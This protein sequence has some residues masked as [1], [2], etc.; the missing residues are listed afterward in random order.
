VPDVARHLTQPRRA[1]LQILAERGP[2]EEAGLTEAWR[3]NRPDMSARHARS[4]PK[5]IRHLL[6]RL[7]ILGWVEVAGD[8]YRLS[9]LGRS[10]VS[11]A[12]PTERSWQN[13]QTNS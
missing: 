3:T 5:M 8:H 10:I 4:L 9:E 6:W 1:V 11:E 2:L 7:E 12:D 13:D